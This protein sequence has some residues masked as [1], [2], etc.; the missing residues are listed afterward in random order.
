MKTLGVPKI[1]TGR[2]YLRNGVDDIVA[3][4]CLA[5]DFRSIT[6]PVHAVPGE[7]ATEVV[8]RDEQ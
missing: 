4:H 3:G 8:D 1:F 5:L 2:L 7:S 6:C